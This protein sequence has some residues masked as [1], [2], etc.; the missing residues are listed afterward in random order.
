MTAFLRKVDGARHGLPED[1]G[2]HG[3][4]QI[5]RMTHRLDVAPAEHV[6]EI[7]T[8]FDEGRSRAAHLVLSLCR[9]EQSVVDDAA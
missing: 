1:L 4:R 6:V 7:A 5:L 2:H 9:L 8:S 3:A